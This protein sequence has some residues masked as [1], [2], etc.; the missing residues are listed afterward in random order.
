MKAFVFGA[1]GALALLAAAPAYAASGY[2]GA[3][4]TRAEIDT[5]AGDADTDVFGIEGAV[6]FDATTSL[7]IDLDAAY[8][9]S[10]DSDSTTGGTAHVY[11][12]G[13][14]YKFGGFVG[15][16][17]ADDTVYS[18][19]LEGQRSFG[20]F[21]LAAA[22]GYANA[23]DADIDAYGV[24]VEGRW[25]AAD[26]FR[27]DGK[28]GYANL[29]GPGGDDDAISVGVGAEY[30][31]AA[32]P[33]SVRGGYS[34]AEFDTADV[35]SDAFTVGIRYNWGGSLKDRDENGP[36]FAGLSSLTSNLD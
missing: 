12:K 4:Y 30:Q 6:A 22:A 28:L 11:G 10:D 31:F 2:V 36:S 5:G 33:V 14:G 25:F 35:S 15:L 13:A 29:D 9:D 16:A 20:R 8:S 7:G 27:L 24:D 21:T 18:V 34:H 32:L 17:D 23:D 26:N 1:V 3:A 19:G